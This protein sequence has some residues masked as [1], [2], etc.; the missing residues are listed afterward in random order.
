MKNPIYLIILLALGLVFVSYK[1]IASA[2]TETEVEHAVSSTTIEDIM[3]R[4]S[5]RSY[6]DREISR[7]QL[8]TLLRAG[9]AAPSAAN[10]QPWRF[11]VVTDKSKLKEIGTNFEY[12]KQADGA[13]AAIIACGD[14]DA[15][16]EGVNS[17]FWIQDVSAASE[18]IL[19]A[20]HAMGLGAVW[21]GI[22]PDPDRVVKFREM[23]A[24]PETIVPMSCIVL[25]YP[26]ASATPKDKWNP[27]NIHYNNW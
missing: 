7:E 5:V 20:A 6:T 2:N 17:G 26:S 24:I 25:G 8:D 10:K 12:M 19:L 27:A 4:T 22:Y 15:T 14:L 18:N 21:C 3:T 1:W 11:V 9:M 23:F 16:F 13:A